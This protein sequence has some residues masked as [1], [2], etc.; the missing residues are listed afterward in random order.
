VSYATDME[1]AAYGYAA[2]LRKRGYSAEVLWYVTALDNLPEFYRSHKTANGWAVRYSSDE[3]TDRKV[4]AGSDAEKR[5]LPVPKFH[6]RSLTVFT[7]PEVTVSRDPWLRQDM[8]TNGNAGVLADFAGEGTVPMYTAAWSPADGP[9][10][11]L[12]PRVILKRYR[13]RTAGE[14]CGLM[15]GPRRMYHLVVTPPAGGPR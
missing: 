8:L 7:G 11:P 10:A 14:A 15:D 6:D 5:G 13:V 9:N 3:A 4:W 12:V 2:E 1:D